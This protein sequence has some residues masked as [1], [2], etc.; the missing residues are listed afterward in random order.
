MVLTNEQKER[1]S[2]IAV[3][4]MYDTVQDFD[5]FKVSQKETLTASVTN[6]NIFQTQVSL[7]VTFSLGKCHLHDVQVENPE[8][9]NSCRCCSFMRF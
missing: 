2:A 1:S 8:S 5:L 4:A 6:N 7:N 3:D 9:G